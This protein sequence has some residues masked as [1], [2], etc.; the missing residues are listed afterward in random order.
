MCLL[1]IKVLVGIQCVFV[2]CEDVM[3]FIC[4]MFCFQVLECDYVSVYFYEWIDLIFGYKQ[5]GFV[6]VEVNNVFYFYCIDDLIKRKL[7]ISM[8]D[9]FG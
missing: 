5:Q 8:I 7:I 6:V 9:N 1:M 3:W 4:Y 2:C